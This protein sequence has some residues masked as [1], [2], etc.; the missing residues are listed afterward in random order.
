MNIKKLDIKTQDKKIIVTIQ[1]KESKDKSLKERTSYETKDVVDLLKKKGYNVGKVLEETKINNYQGLKNCTGTW[2]FKEATLPK[3][4]VNEISKKQTTPP[5][6]PAGVNKPQIK[7][8]RTS[9]AAT[10][11]KGE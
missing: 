9:R 4:K 2:V 3:R 1:I 8:R 6:P 7:R 11:H 10:K 5:P